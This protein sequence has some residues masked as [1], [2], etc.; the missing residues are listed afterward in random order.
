VEASSTGLGVHHQ[1]VL[2]RNKPPTL[3]PNSGARTPA[4]PESE[5]AAK[6][7]Y[8][9]RKGLTEA[10]KMLQ[11]QSHTYEA[12]VQGVEGARKESL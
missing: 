5:G 9:L 7:I 12:T 10:Q 6:S 11:E 2:S 8:V 4:S 1:T 3:T